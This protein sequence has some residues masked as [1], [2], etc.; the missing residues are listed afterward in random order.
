[1][2]RSPS[3]K[4]YNFDA[5]LQKDAERVAEL[6]KQASKNREELGALKS[7]KRRK[8]ASIHIKY[9][10]EEKQLLEKWDS[11][12]RKITTAYSL[13]EAILEEHLEDQLKAAKKEIQRRYPAFKGSR[14]LLNL[15]TV[16][17]RLHD[18][19]NFVEAAEISSR[20]NEMENNEREFYF[21]KRERDVSRKLSA[22]KRTQNLERKALNK[23]AETAKSNAEKQR[24]I[25][26]EA[27]RLKFKNRGA[28]SMSEMNVTIAKRSLKSEKW[29]VMPA[30]NF[31]KV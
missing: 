31:Y 3:Q 25:E 16:E 5:Y 30:H 21:A 27:L 17:K 18:A 7:E 26:V 24:D 4:H 19:S 9:K 2:P 29:A 6:E 15:R 8:A 23:K 10:R 12:L 28:R 20:S 1:M 14:D 13:Q 22:V 11:K